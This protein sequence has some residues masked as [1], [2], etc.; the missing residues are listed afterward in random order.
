MIT[1]KYSKNETK[2]NKINAKSV[3]KKKEKNG[4]IESVNKAREVQIVRSKRKTLSLTV[5]RDGEIVVRAPLR[6]S[7]AEISAFVERH[8]RWLEKRISAVK[9][10]PVL[11]LSDASRVALFGREYTVRTGARARLTSG[12][13]Y[14]PAEDRER[15]LVRLLKR[16]TAARLGELTERIAAQYHF[17]YRGVR[18][19]SAR[20]RWGSCNREGNIAYTFR[21]AFLPEEI[22]V[23]LVV[24]ELCH[25]RFFAH[26]ERFWNEVEGILPNWRK[27]RKS[28]KEKSYIMNFL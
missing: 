4:I 1:I 12:E 8:R 20:T 25:T 2:V 7:Q 10:S 6:T 14:L 18:A 17:T 16:E 23:Y 26:D 3:L 13:L 5:G 28:L 21:A 11:V 22:I 15:S 19:S 9:N 24:H 27:L